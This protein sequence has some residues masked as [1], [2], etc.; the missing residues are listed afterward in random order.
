MRDLKLAGYVARMGER[1]RE[2]GSQWGSL[3]ERGH[4]KDLRVERKIILKWILRK[5]DNRA[6]SEFISLLVNTSIN[7]PVL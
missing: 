1:E 7:L 5:Y 6:L 2:L 3:N 4:F